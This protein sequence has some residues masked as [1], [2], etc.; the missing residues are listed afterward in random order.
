MYLFFKSLIISLL[1]LDIYYNI[2]INKDKYDDICK[3]LKIV[4]N[5]N[6]I[7]N[8]NMIYLYNDN[9]LIIYKNKNFITNKT[10]TINLLNTLSYLIN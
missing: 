2:F 7:K 8:V 9:T 6:V 3:N 4:N 10:D 1:L 5:N